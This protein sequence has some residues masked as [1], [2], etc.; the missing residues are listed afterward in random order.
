MPQ[1]MCDPSIS[2]TCGQ[3]VF[4]QNSPSVDKRSYHGWDHEIIKWNRYDDTTDSWRSGVSDQA[5]LSKFF[6][7]NKKVPPSI[8]RNKE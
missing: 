5:A 1:T 3:N 7:Q 2:A 8:Y 6:K 4:Q